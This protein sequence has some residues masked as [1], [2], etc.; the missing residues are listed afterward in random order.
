MALPLSEELLIAFGTAVGG[1]VVL[2]LFISYV[3]SSIAQQMAQTTATATQS[4]QNMYTLYVNT[5]IAMHGTS[6]LENHA[7]NALLN[8]QQLVKQNQK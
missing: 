4:I 5:I 6:S 1:F 2:W 7:T 8:Q 3:F